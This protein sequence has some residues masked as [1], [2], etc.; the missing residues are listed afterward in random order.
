[1]DVNGR[2]EGQEMT[3]KVSIISH[4]IIEAVGLIQEPAQPQLCHRPGCSEACEAL[5]TDALQR[6]AQ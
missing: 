4:L 5:Q 1:M 6:T 2:K 3:S